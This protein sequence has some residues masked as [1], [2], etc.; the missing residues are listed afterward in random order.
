MLKLSSSYNVDIRS[1][2]MRKVSFRMKYSDAN[3]LASIP[4]GVRLLVA[5]KFSVPR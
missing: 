5:L 3:L 4:D 1:L 2:A